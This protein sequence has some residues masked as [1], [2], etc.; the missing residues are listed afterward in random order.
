MPA[1]AILLSPVLKVYRVHSFWTL[2]IKMYFLFVFI[3]Q[4]NISSFLTHPV[5]LCSTK[6]IEKVLGT[7]QLN[8]FHVDGRVIA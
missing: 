3:A 1:L 4:N 5:T 6:F 7:E 2:D 8:E